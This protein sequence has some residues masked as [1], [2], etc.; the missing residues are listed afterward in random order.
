MRTMPLVFV[1]LPYEATAMKS[2]STGR[3]IARAK[4]LMNTNAPLSTQ[5]SNGARSA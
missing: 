2:T 5:T 3:S 1:E 4:S